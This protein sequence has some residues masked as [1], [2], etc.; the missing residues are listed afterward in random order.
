MCEQDVIAA[1]ELVS[2]IIRLGDDLDERDTRRQVIDPVLR[3][4]GW[5]PRY[6]SGNQDRDCITEFYPYG[7]SSLRADY[8]MFDPD[9]REVIIVEAKRI[10]EHTQDHYDQLDD[11]LDG[12]R[13]MLGVLTNGEYWNISRL[14]ARGRLTEDRPI[15]LLSRSP[16]ESARRLC[17][18]LSKGNWH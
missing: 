2:E 13:Q 3:A 10:R 8:A 18:A 6:G 12:G 16:A 9:G 15:G 1:I 7:D 5:E 14:D 4:L 17:E 11:Y